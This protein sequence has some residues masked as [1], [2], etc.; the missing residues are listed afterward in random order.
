MSRTSVRRSYTL[1][2]P[3]VVIAALVIFG[4]IS[5][6]AKAESPAN[7]R[8]VSGEIR[9][10]YRVPDG[11]TF[12]NGY[13]N[14]VNVRDG[15]SGVLFSLYKPGVPVTR[16]A[17]PADR[18]SE[19]SPVRTKSWFS[20]PDWLKKLINGVKDLISAI[21]GM[22]EELKRVYK[23]IC[24]ILDALG[25]DTCN[26]IH[27]S[28]G[29]NNAAKVAV[30][31]YLGSVHDAAYAVPPSTTLAERHSFSHMQTLN[32]LPV[33]QRATVWYQFSLSIIDKE[34]Y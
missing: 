29:S 26:R 25:L 12:T 5:T 2:L 33:S 20:L 31:T 22:A 10:S 15:R 17:I 27:T 7:W 11:R 16:F 32:R 9:N 30:T 3:L 34:G 13:A 21:Q 23:A 8:V 6:P 19:L 4:S 24:E 18:M 14:I 28:L 1:A